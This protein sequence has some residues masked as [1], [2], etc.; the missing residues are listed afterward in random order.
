MVSQPGSH[1]FSLLILTVALRPENTSTAVRKTLGTSHGCSGS[2]DSWP[3]QE[4]KMDIW[5][6][7]N[8]ATCIAFS[9]TVQS[10]SWAKDVDT[11]WGG[12]GN[13]KG[14]KKLLK[15]TCWTKYCLHTDWHM[16]A[17]WSS[18]QNYFWFRGLAV[19]QVCILQPIYWTQGN[20]CIWVLGNKSL[21]HER[22]QLM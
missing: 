3:D 8:S 17:C 14:L 20:S 21:S 12:R 9:L 19:T 4:A 10:H 5:C 11:P 22:K 2:A 13:E 16:N 18:V 6:T 7:K 15:M 1:F